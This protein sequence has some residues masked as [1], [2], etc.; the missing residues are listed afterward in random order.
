[1][2]INRID[3]CKFRIGSD[4]DSQKLSAV[5]A[6]RDKHLVMPM[7]IEQQQLEAAI[8][9]LQAQRS[10]LG[11]ALV[12][13]ALKPLRARLSSLTASPRLKQVTVLFLDMVGSTT[14]SQQLDPEDVPNVIDGATASLPALVRNALIALQQDGASGAEPGIRGDCAVLAGPCRTGAGAARV[15]AR[16]L[17]A[18]PCSGAGTA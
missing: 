18:R 3:G 14:L 5:I 10:V 16:P 9:T 7:S 11:A 1:M 8:H 6:A 2:K 17:C 15:S 13:A 4:Y 12:D